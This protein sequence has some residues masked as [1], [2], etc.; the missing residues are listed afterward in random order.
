MDI[1]TE[2]DVEPALDM[3]SD[4]TAPAPSKHETPMAPREGD[5]P[6]FPPP[7]STTA[8][9]DQRVVSDRVRGMFRDAAL[10]MSRGEV[11]RDELVPMGTAAAPAPT[12]AQSVEESELEPMAGGE[13]LPAAA[14]PAAK[15][16]AALP[17]PVPRAAAAAP[18]APEPPR[19]ADREIINAANEQRA[20]ELDLREQQLRSRESE[21]DGKLKEREAEIEGR[22]KQLPTRER[23]IETPV[24]AVAGWLKEQYGIT[25][26]TELKD[27]LTDLMT[28]VSVK[29]HNVELPDDVKSKVEGRKAKRQ[30][31]AYTA[32]IERRKADDVKR[33]DEA[34]RTAEEARETAE[35]ETY[36]RKA[37]AQV[38]TLVAVDNRFPFVREYGEEAASLVWK[39]VVDNHKNGTPIDWADAAKELNERIRE[40]VEET[41]A[42]ADRL[43]T[44]LPK[45]APAV[46]S[47][48]AQ[49]PG[50]AS[51][52]APTTPA[53]TA[54]KAPQPTRTDSSDDIVGE[55]RRDRRGRNARVLLQKH[56]LVPGQA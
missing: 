33:A 32:E 52:P 15:A 18:A 36:D 2:N 17:V 16:A 50:S 7:D 53:R 55:D 34:K 48:P 21:I 20:R 49:S 43:R 51:G 28:E 35:R 30:A 9:R 5:N 37:V 56:K 10:K 6:K 22:L 29:Y 31:K 25:D 27:T 47:K 44:L 45:T 42:T 8:V 13:Q 11:D 40:K 54:A 4:R 39:S 23:L 14:S 46:A 12:P 1:E 19:P 26:D 24:D 38:N 3:G 41:V